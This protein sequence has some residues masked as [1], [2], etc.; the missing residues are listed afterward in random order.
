ML[1]KNDLTKGNTVNA[2]VNRKLRGGNGGIL[3]FWV[4]ERGSTKMF[5]EASLG[6]RFFLN[7]RQF[8]ISAPTPTTRLCECSLNGL[9]SSVSPSGE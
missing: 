1:K 8:L 5:G 3:N 6:P 9:T 7:R 2:L 4:T